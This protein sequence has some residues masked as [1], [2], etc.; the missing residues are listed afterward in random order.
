[1]R[2]KRASTDLNR[3]GEARSRTERMYEKGI[4]YEKGMPTLTSNITPPL[5]ELETHDGR[6]RRQSEGP[7]SLLRS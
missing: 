1:V 7:N 5:K 6:R 2:D 3:R 4:R